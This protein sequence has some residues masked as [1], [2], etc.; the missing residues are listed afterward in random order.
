MGNCKICGGK[1]KLTC[2]CPR[3]DSTCENGHE[4]HW[5]PYH[6]E[7]HLGES[8]HTT[9]TF[10]PDCCVDKIKIEDKEAIDAKQAEEIRK[11]EEERLRQEAEK[12]AAKAKANSIINTIPFKTEQAARDGKS[13][14]DIMILEY[15]DYKSFTI[16]LGPNDLKLTARMVYD[17]LSENGLRP[18]F[19]KEYD[20][21]GNRSWYVIKANW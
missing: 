14:A 21:G 7:W 3:S 19:D 18:T 11:A 8:N 4:Y 5:S 12:Q 17:F 2:R 1:I 15:G 13:S 20:D 16:H 6:K 10:S 9:D